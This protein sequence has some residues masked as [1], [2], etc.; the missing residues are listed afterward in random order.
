MIKL[1]LMK[2]YNTEYVF[3][4]FL[5]YVGLLIGIRELF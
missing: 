5:E 1:K 4:F 2:F 3:V